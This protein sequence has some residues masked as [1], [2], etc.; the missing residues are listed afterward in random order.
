M[1]RRVRAEDPR[2][3]SHL[4]RGGSGESVGRRRRSLVDDLIL[5]VLALVRDEG[6]SAGS[7]LPST[8]TLARRFGVATPTMREALLR[9]EATG[10]VSIRHGSGTFVRDDAPRVV[11]A[12][13]SRQTSE[14]MTLDV[15]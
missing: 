8:S 4:P 7:R 12:N 2:P 5:D 3:T 10:V 15:L 6:L 14:S 9:L 13:P 11:I 1:P